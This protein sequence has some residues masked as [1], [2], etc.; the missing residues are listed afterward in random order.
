MSGMT[1]ILT[2]IALSA[3]SGVL[4]WLLPLPERLRQVSTTVFLSAGS[5]LGLA[6]IAFALGETTTAYMSLPW[7]LPSGA[8]LLGLD[9]LSA[10]FL[11]PVF[12]IS[13]LGSVYGMGYWKASAHPGNWRR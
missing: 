3:L 4:P 7:F 1:L 11:V 13:A 5:L 8:F 12:A 2:A 9:G 10:A 6:G